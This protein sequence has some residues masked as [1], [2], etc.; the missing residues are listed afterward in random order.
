MEL[1]DIV[2]E[3]GNF[4]GKVMDKDKAHDLNLLHWEVAMFVINSKKQILMQKRSP[5]K[6]FNPNVWAICAGHVDAGEELEDAAIRELEEEI[7]LKIFKNELHLLKEIEVKKR[8]SNSHLTRI[9]YVIC[10]KKENEF[11]IQEEELSEVK[12][13]DIPQI[14]KMIKTHDKCMGFREDR[15]HFFEELKSIKL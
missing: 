11:N 10:N 5:K 3:N 4:T 15:L 7:G 1:I 2:D 13:F 12:W 14:I 6:R 8:E 9:Y